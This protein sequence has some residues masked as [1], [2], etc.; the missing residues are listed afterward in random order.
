MATLYRSN[1]LHGVGSFFRMGKFSMEFCINV[2]D[3]FVAIRLL[4]VEFF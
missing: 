1:S 3:I 4:F 2:G